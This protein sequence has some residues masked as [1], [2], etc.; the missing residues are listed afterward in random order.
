M[1]PCG[2]F[3]LATVGNYMVV[4][5]DVC[6]LQGWQILLLFREDIEYAIIMIN[7]K[8]SLHKFRGMHYNVWHRKEFTT[9]V[10]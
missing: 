1:F 6:N 7:A 4:Y 2:T 5:H 9:V 3:F 8:K 10:F